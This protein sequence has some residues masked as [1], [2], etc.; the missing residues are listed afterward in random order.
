MKK[1]V[2]SIIEDLTND[3][4]IAIIMN[5]AQVVAFNIKDDNFKEWIK[6]EQNGYGDG[7]NL[8]DYRKVGCAV[9]AKITNTFQGRL[10]F[11]VPIDAITKKEIRERLSKITFFESISEL[12]KMGVCNDKLLT[13]NVSAFVFPEINKIFPTSNIEAVWQYTNVSTAAAI[14]DKV[15]SMLL[16]FFLELDCQLNWSIDFDALTN[17]T[18]IINIMSTT[19]NAAIVNTGDGY[20]ESNQSTNMGGVNNTMNVS[21]DVKL[22]IK[23]LL[24]QIS[25][26][27]TQLGDDEQEIAEYILEIKQELNKKNSSPK[28][29]KTCCRALKTFSTIVQEKAIEIGLDKVISSFS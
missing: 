2:E 19:I 29:L 27:K 20:I 21:D 7:S 9:K 18:K 14:V 26:I 17:K 5:K 23:D 12:E 4:S 8:P 16:N 1:I 24:S 22:Q 15:K 11:E 25:D 3:V 6:N 28:V 10:N 13:A